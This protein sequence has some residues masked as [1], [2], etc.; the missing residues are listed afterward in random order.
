MPLKVRT[1]KGYVIQMEK[2]QQHEWKQE[3][4]GRRIQRYCYCYYYYYYYY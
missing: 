4:I 2:I 3:Q 1:M